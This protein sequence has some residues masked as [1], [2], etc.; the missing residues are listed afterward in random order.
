MGVDFIPILPAAGTI[1]QRRGL[2]PSPHLYAHIRPSLAQPGWTGSRG[3]FRSRFLTDNV[4]KVMDLKIPVNTKTI[5][6]SVC[7][8]KKTYVAAGIYHQDIHKF[9]LEKPA[10]DLMQFNPSN[11][12]QLLSKA[13]GCKDFRKPSKPCHVGIHWKA[14]AEYS[15]LSTHMPGFQ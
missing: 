5:T 12:E 8:R 15:H 4:R 1:P 11:A 14:L 7:M 2:S 3:S 9:S 13:R 10:Y 6:P